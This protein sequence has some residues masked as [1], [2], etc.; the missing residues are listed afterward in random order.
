VFVWSTQRYDEAVQLFASGRSDYEIA[1]ALGIPRSTIQKWRH[2]A[3]SRRRRG[4]AEL[5]HWRPADAT[6][7]AYVLGLYLGDGCVT[8]RPGKT[9]FMVVTLDAAYRGLIDEAVEALDAALTPPSVRRYE[10]GGG[11]YVILQVGGPWVTHAFP[12]HGPGHKH[13]RKIELL[14]WQREIT[15][16]HPGALVRGLIHSDGCRTI[17]R[18]KTKLPSG[19]VKEYAYPRYFFSNLSGDIRAIFVEHCDLLGVRCTMS[20]AR[21]V[22]VSHRDSVAIL[23][24]VVGPKR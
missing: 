3:P 7:Y 10:R 14:D 17:N 5:T 12:Q 22:S 18:F 1:R 19:R 2:R 21:N 16:A 9:P 8:A 11:T 4:V 15:H 24:E 13:E 23:E 6:A 20:N